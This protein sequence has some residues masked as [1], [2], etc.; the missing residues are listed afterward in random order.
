M[1]ALGLFIFSILVCLNFAFGQ[2][3]FPSSGNVGI[4]T[5]NPGALLDVG[6]LLNP[7]S[8]GSVLARLSEGNGSGAG[9]Y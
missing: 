5:T 2:N 7:G 6:A 1:K 8:L 4:G 3:T 9:T